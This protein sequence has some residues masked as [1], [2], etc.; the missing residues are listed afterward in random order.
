LLCLPELCD[1]AITNEVTN[2][3]CYKF[4]NLD[5]IKHSPQSDK[6]WYAAKYEEDGKEEADLVLL[7]FAAL[8]T[9]GSR[10]RS[11][12]DCHSS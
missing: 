3:V 10:S 7:F 1:A 2:N 4:E 11:F 5:G 8:D 6:S 12:S 9:L